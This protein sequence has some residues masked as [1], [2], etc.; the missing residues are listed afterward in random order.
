[1]RVFG[2]GFIAKGFPS[3]TLIQPESGNITGAVNKV[4]YQ[5][6]SGI[7]HRKRRNKIPPTGST[8]EHGD[9]LLYALFIG[10]TIATVGQQTIEIRKVSPLIFFNG[11]LLFLP[12]LLHELYLKPYG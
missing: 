9:N 2:G 5:C 6:I 8:L 3:S 7:E 1:M 4:I 12:A 10:N 11:F